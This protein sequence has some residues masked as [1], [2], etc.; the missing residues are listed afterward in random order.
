MAKQKWET[1]PLEV[2]NKAKE[3][4]AKWQKSIDTASTEKVLLAQGNCQWSI[5]FPAL[6][7]IEDNPV[8]A[9]MANKSDEFA[10]VARWAGEILGWGREI[11]GYQLN[12]WGAMYL[13]YQIDGSPF[14]FRDLVIPFSDPCDQ[15]TKRGQAPMDYSP[16]PRF[17]ENYPLYTGPQDSARDK[18]LIEDKVY[19]TL[20]IIQEI[21]RIFG[22]KF[23]DEKFVESVKTMGQVAPYAR[24]VSCF[25]QHIPSP[26]SQKDLYSFYTLGGLTKG[27]PGETVAI[28]KALRDE[29]EWR[30]QNNIAAVGNER[31]RWMEAHPPPWH[32]LKY[33]RYMEK[34]G[35]VCIGSQYSHMMAGPMEL[36]KDGTWG[37]RFSGGGFGRT[38]DRPIK[39]REDAIRVMLGTE[40][41]G[42]RFKDDEVIRPWALNDFAKAYKVDGAILP[43]WRC[44]VG[45]TVTRKEQGLRLSEMGVHVLHYEGSQPG[46]RT[47]LDENRLLDQVDVWMESQGLRKL[48][49]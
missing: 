49:D 8:G 26:L 35:A 47:D 37:P 34:Y 17:Q 24:E 43:L 36:K 42:H 6:R 38:I 20:Y 16:I 12:C 39:T 29:V 31:Y 19:T 41:R 23:D 9:M 18:A 22:Q 32:F 28:W 25:M 21:E 5:G 44:G 48:E 46:D 40:A 4:R 14:P 7:V 33:Y 10:R 45:C 3:M 2:W 27:D 13:G 15:H 30:V 1:R 11:C